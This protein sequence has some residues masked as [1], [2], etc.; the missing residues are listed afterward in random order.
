MFFRFQSGLRSV[1]IDSMG[2]QT[3]AFDLLEVLATVADPCLP[4]GARSSIYTTGL[5]AGEIEVGYLDLLRA[6]V[7]AN[8]PMPPNLIDLASDYVNSLGGS[9]WADDMKVELQELVLRV[10]RSDTP[11]GDDLWDFATDVIAAHFILSDAGLTDA[12]HDQQVDAIR[13][14]LHRNKPGWALRYSMQWE[15]FG[16]LLAG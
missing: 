7:D 5:W 9:E 8:Y 12:P 13:H 11:A 15:G 1:T 6:V 14:W 10:K 3:D 16:D 4:E 2:T